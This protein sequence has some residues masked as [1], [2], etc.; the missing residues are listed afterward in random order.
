MKEVK[1]G[2]TVAVTSSAATVIASSLA[3]L[4]CGSS[5]YLGGMGLALALIECGLIFD[6][7]RATSDHLEIIHTHPFQ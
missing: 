2:D 3:T 6:L 4:L 1:V 5:S 7:N